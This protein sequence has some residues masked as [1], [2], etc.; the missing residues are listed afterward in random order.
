[1]GSSFT[2]TFNDNTSIGGG[3]KPHLPLIPQL[4]KSSNSYSFNLNNSSSENVFQG[5]P[6]V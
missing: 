6:G 3:Q 4:Q 5:Q 1:M 2:L